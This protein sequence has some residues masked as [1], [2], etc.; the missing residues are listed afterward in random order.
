MNLGL[1]AAVQ[2]FQNGCTGG[3][4]SGCSQATSGG[5]STTSAAVTTTLLEVIGAIAVIMIVIG[6]LRLV[7]SGGNPKQVE[8]ARNSILYA[9]VGLLI[10]SLAYVMVHFVL[11]KL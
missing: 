5:L 8:E 3:G 2:V 4:D 1:L 6:G 7:L 11:G 9:V 10:A